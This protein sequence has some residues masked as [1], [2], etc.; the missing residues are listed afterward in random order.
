VWLERVWK[1]I[2]YGFRMLAASRAFTI[3]AV[4]SLAIGIGANSAIFSFADALLLRP[5]TV[6]RPGEVLTVGSRST[7]DALNG[8]SLVSSYR[9]YVDIRD[10]NKSFEGLAAFSFFTAGFATDAT[11][12]PKLTMG[13]LVSGNL[14]PLMGV[15]PT[16]GRTFRPEEDQVPGRDAVV[17]LGRTFWEQT[18]GS[19]PGILGRTVRIKGVPFT[20]IGVAPPAFTG[21][22]QF[23]RSDFYVPLMMSPRIV[24]DPKAA[25]L[26]ARDARNLRIKGRLKPGVTQAQAQ[27]ELTA[28]GL[29]LQ[30]AYPDTNKNRDFVVRTELQS[31]IGEDPPDA[32]LVAMLS[33]LAIAVLLVACGNVAGLLASRAPVR[34]REMALRLAIGAGR[35]QLMRQLI[36][37]SLLIALAGGILGIGVGYAGMLMFRQV[38]IPTDLPIVLAF[39]MDQRALFFSFAVAVAS[40]LFFGIVPAIQASRTDLTAIMKAGDAIAPGRRRRWGRAVL[41][42]GQVAVSVV[43]LV[44]ALFMYGGFR[45]ELAGGPGYRIDHLLM[46]RF[47]PKLVR[48]TDDQSRQFFEQVAERSRAVSGVKSVT[49]TSAIPMSNDSLDFVTIAPEGFQFPQGKDNATT[50]ASMVDEHYFDTIGIP[51]LE[52]RN[53]ARTDDAGAPRVAIVNQHMAQH[54]WPNASAIGKR[55]RLT[56]DD[57]AWVQVVGVAKTTKYVFIAEPPSDCVY[58]PYRQN[59]VRPMMMLSQSMG[60]AAGLTAPLRD[61]VHGL[62]VNMPIFDVRTMEE[63]YTLRAIRVFSVL[64]T[65]VVAMGVMALA[66]AIVGL[67]GLVAYA[68]SRRTREIG[69]RMAIGATAPTVL[70][71]VLRQGFVL[72][73]IGLVI[74]L[75]GSVGAGRL[76]RAAFPTGA[77]RQSGIMPLLIVAAI[78]LLVTILAAYIPARRASRVNPMDALRYE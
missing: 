40:A 15:E 3:V 59:S 28:I 50:L 70:R 1:D 73:T 49:M 22:D 24:S 56:D 16:I 20:V 39:R 37:E 47:D 74:G 10:R 11:A 29:D 42:T 45:Q 60:D 58:M 9:D 41:V 19:D 64:I 43:V 75:A 48:Y 13:M 77:E 51:L 5:L 71:L 14:L 18:L 8:S 57:N 65:T 52:G 62:D 7:I 78:V 76:L 67:Y 34:A 46:M 32:M 17:I 2:R 55:F 35:G 25:S 68:A 36:T 38:E 53:F 26:E 23:V 69:I 44:V 61:V 31:R 54:Y 66:L 6:A 12:T 72:A 21:M 27:A 4:L 63:L 30:R 33:T